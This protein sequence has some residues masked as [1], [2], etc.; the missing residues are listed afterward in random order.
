VVW[1]RVFERNARL[2]KSTPLLGVTGRVQKQQ[3]VVHIIVQKMWKP[4]L[5]RRLPAVASRDFH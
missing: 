4:E 3:G 2:A 1:P 5:H